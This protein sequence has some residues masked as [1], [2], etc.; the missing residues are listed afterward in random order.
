MK[1]IAELPG[2][3]YLESD[4][5]N[6]TF[7]KH[8]ACPETRALITEFQTQH[9]KDLKAWPLPAG[10][11]HSVLLLRELIEKVQGTWKPPFQDEEICHCRNINAKKIDQCVV[12]GAKNIAQLKRMSN[13]AASCG[14]CEP[15]VEEILHFRRQG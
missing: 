6:S 9:G 11:S 8:V 13:A 4:S 10:D 5:E 1:V 14:T 2:Q 12:M 15:Q 7:I 3:D